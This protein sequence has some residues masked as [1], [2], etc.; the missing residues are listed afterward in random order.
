MDDHLKKDALDK[1]KKPLALVNGEV[2][3]DK[4]ADLFIPPD[5]LEILLEAFEGPLDFLLYLIRKHQ[6]DILNLP[7][8]EITRQYVAYIDMMQVLQM[9]L[10][11]DYLVM[12]AMLAEIK[13][14][15]LLPAIPSDESEEEDPRAELVRRLQ[16][17]EQYKEAATTLDKMPRVDRDVF[18]AAA[19]RPN[20]TQPTNQWPQV[21]LQ[22]LTLAF[23]QVLQRAK[24]FEHHQIQH[25][26]LSTRERMAAILAKL[27][28]T[29][30]PLPFS[31]FFSYQEGRSGAVVTFIAILE[32]MKDGVID[33][34]QMR[35]YSPM[36][37][38]LKE[39]QV[40]VKP[41]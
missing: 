41:D 39:L 1:L 2:V 20:E 35:N 16:L 12:A 19:E 27:Q 24:A 40:C 15:L 37:V 26:Q 30:E 5:A 13:S 4:P 33:L 6:F 10:A 17:Y 22:D 31:D 25:E 3:I 9:E 34:T 28:S 8:Q 11:A 18:I 21:S 36:Y 23:Q 38:S 29:T 32:L 7:I 14:R